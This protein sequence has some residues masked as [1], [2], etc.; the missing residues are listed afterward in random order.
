[1]KK[2][3]IRTGRLVAGAR[4]NEGFFAEFLVPTEGLEP[5]RL[6]AHGPEPCASTNS[7]TWA[8]VRCAAQNAIIAGRITL[9]SILG[10]NAKRGWKPLSICLRARVAV[11]AGDRISRK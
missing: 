3:F 5:P 1:M 9:S 7:A 8:R 10:Q 2:A 6:A 11:S 4:E